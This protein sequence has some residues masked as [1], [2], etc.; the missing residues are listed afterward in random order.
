MTVNGH[1]LGAI[2]LNQRAESLC[3][4]I[5]APTS[6]PLCPLGAVINFA[7]Y[8]EAL[9]FISACFPPLSGTIHPSFLQSVLTANH[10]VP[11]LAVV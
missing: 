7:R 6:L 8:S 11:L 1:A 10:I 2:I 9:N 4:L 3:S 5:E